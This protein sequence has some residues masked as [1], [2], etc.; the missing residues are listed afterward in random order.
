MTCI[1]MEII[2]ELEEEDYNLIQKMRKVGTDITSVQL[3][4][5]GDIV[6]NNIKEV[7]NE[8]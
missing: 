1:I 3:A 7:K 2:I 8:K 4:L 5:V 6:L